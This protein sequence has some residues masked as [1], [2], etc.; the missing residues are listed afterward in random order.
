MYGKASLVWDVLGM[1]LLIRRFLKVLVQTMVVLYRSQVQKVY[2]LPYH[3]RVRWCKVLKSRCSSEWWV[4]PKFESTTPL[5][6]NVHF[7]VKIS[8]TDIIYICQSRAFWK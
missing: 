6:V 1:S 2:F 5:F 3:C 7:Y 8:M 4:D